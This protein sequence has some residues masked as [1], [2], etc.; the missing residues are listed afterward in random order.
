MKQQKV[1]LTG[2][3][4][5]GKDYIAERSGG[6]IIGFADPLYE[7]GRILTGIGPD[8]KDTVP[9]LRELYQKIGQ[10]G[11]GDVSEKYPLSMERCMFSLIVNSGV[12]DEALPYVDFSKWGTGGDIW[13]DALFRRSGELPANRIFVSNCRFRNEYDALLA[14]GWD[15]WHVMCSRQTYEERL[16][17]VGLSINSKQISDTSEEL[18]GLMDNSV[19]NAIKQQPVGPKL[20]VVWN[21]TRPSPCDRLQTLEQFQAYLTNQETEPEYTYGPE[22]SEETT[23]DAGSGAGDGE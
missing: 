1:A 14:G 18:A 10:W 11:R 20:K 7:I 22:T 2:R 12:F 16:R 19:I 6:T 23:P 17:E 21:D 4:R 8:K 3:L 9:F 15:H 13:L 5:T